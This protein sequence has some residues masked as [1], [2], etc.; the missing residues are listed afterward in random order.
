MYAA[1]YGI[2]MGC[3]AWC[4]RGLVL[5]RTSQRTMTVV[6][7]LLVLNALV[8]ALLVSGVAIDFPSGLIVGFVYVGGY[9]FAIIGRSD[10]LQLFGA[11][12][13][14]RACVWYRYCVV[15]DGIADFRFGYRPI[16]H[17]FF[18]SH[19]F[20][21]VIMIIWVITVGGMKKRSDGM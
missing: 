8:L 12:C 7:W 20:T 18:L 14:V 16:L 9:G 19:V 4:F 6:R 21:L 1:G 15:K 11:C 2:M 3:Q 5:Y 10:S 13:D 17:Y